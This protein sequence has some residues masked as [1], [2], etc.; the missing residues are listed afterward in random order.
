L[1]FNLFIFF[2][3]SFKPKSSTSNLNQ[4]INKNEKKKMKA[5]QKDIRVLSTSHLQT[6]IDSRKKDTE[7]EAVLLD[8]SSSGKL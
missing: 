7:Y 6:S 3:S 4:L 1:R 2:Y 5:I 8:S